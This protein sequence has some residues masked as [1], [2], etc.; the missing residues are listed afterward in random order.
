MND[1]GDS[2]RRGARASRPLTGKLDYLRERLTQCG[3]LAFEAARDADADLRTRWAHAELGHVV[4]D[5]AALVERARELRAEII[6]KGG[7]PHALAAPIPLVLRRP[8][9]PFMPIE[10]TLALE[11][12]RKP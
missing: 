2:H 8:D 10:A 3:V 9:P 5:I 6:A 1:R 4:A 11:G 12:D 7:G